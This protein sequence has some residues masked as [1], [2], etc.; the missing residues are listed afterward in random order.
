MLGSN[1]LFG[2]SQP[3]V[4]LGV[5]SFFDCDEGTRIRI[6]HF[7]DTLVERSLG[8]PKDLL[9][10][11]LAVEGGEKRHIPFRAT[12]FR[13]H[14]N[15]I[16]F[17]EKYASTEGIFSEKWTAWIIVEVVGGALD[18]GSRGLTWGSRLEYGYFFGTARGP[19]FAQQGEGIVRPADAS[20]A[21]GSAY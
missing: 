5:R 9:L 14:V 19:A 2:M 11:G 8:S 21:E 4:G 18:D 7:G 16:S 1:S 10:L 6:E 20:K 12:P 3:V 17:S 13:G 15:Q